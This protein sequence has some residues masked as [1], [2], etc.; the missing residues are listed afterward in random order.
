[1]STNGHFAMDGKSRSKL[2]H[3]IKDYLLDEIKKDCGEDFKLIEDRVES[4]LT[5]NSLKDVKFLIRAELNSL[6]LKN[7]G[8][9][10]RNRDESR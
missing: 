8:R 9:Q 4:F 10:D 3:R 1:M 2:D 5:S 6:K 7:A